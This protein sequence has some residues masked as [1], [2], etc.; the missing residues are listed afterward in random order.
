M[1]IAFIA[2]AVIQFNAL[3][4][5]LRK[6]RIISATASQ[7]YYSFMLGSSFYLFAV[8]R[9]V[10]EPPEGFFDPR[11]KFIYTACIAYFCRCILTWDRFVSWSVAL[12][13]VRVAKTQLGL[14]E[15]QG[16]AM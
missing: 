2:I 15:Y 8:R 12:L 14:F 7:A 16:S 3:N 11:L 5:T 1:A 13:C 4:M 6:K 10:A 9:F